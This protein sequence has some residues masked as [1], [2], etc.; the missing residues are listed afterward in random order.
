[1]KR[2][3]VF[4]VIML[5]ASGLGASGKI[6]NLNK[7]AEEETP[8]PSMSLPKPPEA[9]GADIGKLRK[10]DPV[11]IDGDAALA[12]FAGVK[13]SGTMEDPY[14]IENL[15]FEISDKPGFSVEKTAKHLVLRN[16]S[17]SGKATDFPVQTPGI[18]I[19]NS[20]NVRILNCESFGNDGI[21]IGGCKN[22]TVERCLLKSVINGIFSSGGGQIKAL[23]NYVSDSVK[24]GVFLYNGPDAEIAH[25][26][27]E[28]TGR[29]GIGTNGGNSF[30]H[31]YHDNVI[32]HCGWTAINLEVNFRSDSTRPDNSRIENNL[33]G[34]SHYGIILMGKDLTCKNNKVFYSSQDGLLVLE[35]SGLEIKNNIIVYAGLNGIDL[36]SGKNVKIEDNLI[37]QTNQGIYS[38]IGGVKITGNEFQQFFTGVKS[39]NK[40]GNLQ[41]T[42]NRFGYGRNGV[43]LNGDGNTVSENTFSHQ[44]ISA[45][46]GGDRN[47]VVGNNFRHTGDV[48][49]ISGSGNIFSDNGCFNINYGGIMLHKASN[50]KITR[51]L[52]SNLT[53]NVFIV[54]ESKDNIFSGN[55]VGNSLNSFNNGTFD[56]TK[57]ES[58]TIDG[59]VFKNINLLIRFKDANS[60]GNIF[61]KNTYENVGKNI[62]D[63]FKASNPE[64]KNHFDVQFQAA[65]PEQ[66]QDIIAGKPYTSQ[67]SAWCFYKHVKLAG[68]INAQKSDAGITK[69]NGKIICEFSGLIP[70]AVP[71]GTGAVLI[72]PEEIPAK[73]QVNLSFK[74]RLIDGE[75]NLY[76]VRLFGGDSRFSLKLEKEAN[77]FNVKMLLSDT[78]PTRHIIFSLH[79]PAVPN[80]VVPGKLELSDITLQY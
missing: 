34:Y 47:T 57:A 63:A 15:C 3:S 78:Y 30:N 73:K 11:A 62:E 21:Y 13:G 69:E 72:L 71:W 18:S 70:E 51:N 5:T 61:E 8:V 20:S 31:Y 7:P 67:T 1:M 60:S 79:N 56:F 40:I 16:I 50:T 32:M 58:N 49:R 22:V 10:S 17:V 27:V 44:I 55:A 23:Y 64:K 53:A 80:S 14:V 35:A 36:L 12:S 76:I 46:I 6:M 66:K 28:W 52:V 68:K 9:V 77:E 75:G 45:S 74:A 2:I 48:I 43:V 24:Y 19:K 54:N 37:F 39:D 33:V 65:L 38:K 59:N 4:V 29:E 41:V 25:N 26:Y 42:K